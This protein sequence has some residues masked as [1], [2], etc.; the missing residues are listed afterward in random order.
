MK[1]KNLSIEEIGKVVAVSGP[2]VKIKGLPDVQMG[3]TLLLG[4]EQAIVFQFGREFTSALIYEYFVYALSL[5]ES[6]NI[7]IGEEVKM[8]KKVFKIPVGEKF[9]GRVVDPLGRD[10]NYQDLIKGESFREVEALPPEI[11]EREQIEEPLE[12][13]IKIIDAL[14]PIGRGQ[15]ELIVG[16]RKTGKTTLGLD[17]ILNQKDVICLYASIGQQ[18]A[19]IV[20]TIKTLRDRGALDYTI[21]VAASS[22]HPPVLQYLAPFSAM[23]MAEYFRDKG[24][25]VLIVFDDLTKHAWIWRE[26]SLQLKRPPGRESYP[27]DIFYLHARL[28]ERAAKLNKSGGGGSISALPICETKEGDISE[29]IPTNLISITDG[30]LYLETSLF[31]EGAKP[32]INIGLSVSRIGSRAQREH[33]K[34][35]TRG[36][37]LILSQHKELK[38]LLQLETKISKESQKNFKRGELFIGIFKQGK[39]QLISA[40]NQSIMYFA[41]LEGFLDDLDLKN[42]KK[43]ESDFYK[44]ID[45]FHFRL[46]AK[47]EKEGWTK[48]IKDEVGRAI[49]EFKQQYED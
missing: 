32:A 24:K 15:R 21:V 19:E 38:K 31:Q 23:T 36:L 18:R 49:K 20:Q 45:K 27:G 39:H 33:I 6:R 48:E 7:K 9:I 28:L 44:F 34:D 3:E 13:G 47:L 30:Q 29:Y 1:N 10:I 8:T 46:K 43:F 11:M 12:T 17:A 42:L 14:F 16:D 40:I 35:V 41:I 22:S 5:G 26:I 2:V 25:D 4:K 37:K